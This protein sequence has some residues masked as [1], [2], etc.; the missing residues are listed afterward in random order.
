MTELRITFLD[1]LGSELARVAR[2]RER[3]PRRLRLL[4]PAAHRR[5]VALAVGA[6]VLLSGGAY[7]VPVTRGAIDTITGSFAGW[8][9]G[10]TDE[11]PGVPVGPGDDNVPAWVRSA[12][13]TRLIAKSHGIGLYVKRE[14]HYDG[15]HIGL[16]VAV[17]NGFGESATIEDW[18]KQFASHAVLVMGPGSVHGKP[19]DEHGFFPLMGLTNRKVVRV[20]LRYESGEPTVAS[21]VKGGFVLWTDA[22][23]KLRELVVYDKDGK[24]L[25]RADVTNVDMTRVCTYAEGCPP[26]PFTYPPAP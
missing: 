23:R 2:E 20:E 5:A 10:D 12:K 8:V 21:H 17:G 25:E 7:A 6:A 16:S 4:G 9:R 1:D 11:A 15:D 14:A 26:R 24:E 18:R 19:W 3:S 13:D 22:H